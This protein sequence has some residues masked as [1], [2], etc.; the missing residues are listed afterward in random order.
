MLLRLWFIVSV[1]MVALRSRRHHIV[2]GLVC[3]VVNHVLVEVRAVGSGVDCGMGVD[4]RPVDSTFLE[5][6]LLRISSCSTA[7]A[8]PWCS[9]KRM[10]RH[11]V[12]Q[13]IAVA[14]ETFIQR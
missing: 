9:T 12:V 5:T 13:T 7:K 11:A 3:T 2:V 1:D 6:A 10:E 14:D 8:L 4:G